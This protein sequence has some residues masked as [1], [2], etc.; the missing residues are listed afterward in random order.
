MKDIDNLLKN[1]N[2]VIKCQIHKFSNL[3][4]ILGLD[5]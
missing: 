1:L 5:K 2:L 3:L 4:L